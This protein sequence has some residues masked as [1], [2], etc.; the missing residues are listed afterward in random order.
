MN[1]SDRQKN[2]LQFIAEFVGDHNF[3][4]TIR[5]IGQAVGI[6]STSVVKYN[7]SKLEK[8]EL[9]LRQKEVSRGLCLNW[10]KLAEIGLA[11]NLEGAESHLDVDNAPE[12]GFFAGLRIP[13]LGPIAAG[14]PIQV[15]PQQ[16]DTADEWIELN[17]SLFRKPTQLYALRVQGDSM[18]DASVLD[19][20]I[21]VL[22]HQTEAQNGE[23]V[24]AWIEGE[25]ETTL[26]HFYLKG[27]RVELKPANPSYKVMEFPADKVQ[28]MGKV[29]S[30]IRT[31]E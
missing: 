23:M 14:Q 19:G 15:E 30:V 20:D 7:L 17:S 29:V 10:P 5:E 26:K 13:V 18:I 24:A 27:D 1:L 6:S 31:L 11:G 12:N 9:I 2:I 21:V 25:N 8:D 4:P 3:P 22:R 16:F 28:V